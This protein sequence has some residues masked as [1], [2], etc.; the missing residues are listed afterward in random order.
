MTN[1][2]ICGQEQTG[3]TCPACSAEM[4]APA[5]AEATGIPYQTLI[6]ALREGRLQGRRVGPRAWLSSRAAVAAAQ[7]AGT[8][9]ATE[10]Q[11]TGQEQE[12][13]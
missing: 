5:L 8:M 1:C 2:P 11:A 7:A 9:R 6:F 10:R 13:A 4:T 12:E 3:P